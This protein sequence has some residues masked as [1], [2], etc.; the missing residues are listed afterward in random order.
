[1]KV[2]FGRVSGWIMVAGLAAG[3]LV[4]PGA[5]DAGVE[6]EIAELRRELADVKKELAEMK[7]LL[8]GT[9][10]ARAPARGTA[11]VSVAGRPSQGAHDAPVTMVEFSDYQCPFCKRHFSTVFPAIKKDY[12]DTGKLK[13]VFRDFPI[14]SLHPQA[15]KA[16]EAAHCAREQDQYWAMHHIL[17]EKSTDFS[18][19]ALKRY[20]REA[21]LDGDTFDE[22]LRAGGYA[23]RVEEEMADGRKVG[24]SGTPSFV[25]GATGSGETITGTVVIGAQ[26]HDRFKQAIESAL[27]AMS[28]S[29]AD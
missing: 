19:D 26:P 22:C 2:R 23:S 11:E 12:I 1:M 3:V 7:R 9:R 4:C 27:K 13:Y 14:P 17:F 24:I 10:P 6:E 5:S 29:H 18:V 15:L 21:G 16:H 20:A 28:T 8:Q 25:I